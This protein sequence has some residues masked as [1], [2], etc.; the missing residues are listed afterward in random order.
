[1]A[2]IFCTGLLYLFV[3]PVVSDLGL[4]MLL[5]FVL[6]FAIS[7][8]FP[9]RE[10]G[11]MK[12]GFMMPWLAVG[13]YT[14]VPAYS[15]MNLA[16]G[17][18]TLLVGIS[19]SSLIRYVFFSP[20]EEVLFL[21][22]QTAFFR[23]AERLLARFC[24][25]YHGQKPGFVTRLRYELALRRLHLVVDGLNGMVGKLPV[26]VMEPEIARLFCAEAKDI[27]V[28]LQRLYADAVA[29]GGRLEWETETKAEAGERRETPGDKPPL[30]D[31]PGGEG[32]GG[33]LEPENSVSDK[34]GQRSGSAPVSGLERR[35]R[36]MQETTERLLDILHERQRRLEMSAPADS[37]PEDAAGEM[38]RSMSAQC[39]SI[40]KGLLNTLGVA[41][42]A[43][44][45]RHEGN[46]F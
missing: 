35:V 19:L 3:Y 14:N 34:D 7:F 40:L 36:A 37:G 23:E 38:L 32:I 43:P 1:M 42:S 18:F 2:G 10:Q 22:R 29:L 16:A 15:F 26:Q 4:F 41:R 24:N 44:W 20:N 31:L 17:S 8:L 6:A 25:D 13:H 27:G 33:T 39:G 11:A 21:R 9:R 28:A 45:T 12:M 46:H 5:T 30:P